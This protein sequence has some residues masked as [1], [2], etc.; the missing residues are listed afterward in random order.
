MTKYHFACSVFTYIAALFFFLSCFGRTAEVL[1]STQQKIE[2]NSLPQEGMAELKILMSY[3]D[4]NGWKLYHPNA[5][6]VLLGYENAIKSYEIGQLD[7]GNLDFFM[8]EKLQ[9]EFYSK[10]KENKLFKL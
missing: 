6:A 8:S 4:Q 3:R 1:T 7:H 10:L 9:N 5:K 2:L